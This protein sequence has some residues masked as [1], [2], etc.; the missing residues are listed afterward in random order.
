MAECGFQRQNSILEKLGTGLVTAATP[1]TVA[2]EAAT[3]AATA[4]PAGAATAAAI[5]A[6]TAAV[7]AAA[8]PAVIA[9]AILTPVTIGSLYVGKYFN[10]RLRWNDEAKEEEFKRQFVAHVTKKQHLIV[11]ST[12]ADCS[13]QVE[14]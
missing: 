11:D 1:V 10:E 2:A 8:V 4:A 13:N 7:G 5:A 14:P 9:V 3:A 6:G 12:S